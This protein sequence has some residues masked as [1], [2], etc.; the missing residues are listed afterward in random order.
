MKPTVK[1]IPKEKV[2]ILHVCEQRDNIEKLNLILVGNGH[3]E[4]G[5]VFKVVE[6]G[7]EI[8]NINEKLTGIS[9]IVKEL[10]EESVGKKEVIK[11]DKERFI[12]GI[13]TLG[14]LITIITLLFTAYNS[15]IG[16]KKQDIV[17]NKV[18]S[19]EYI[20][21]KEIRQMEGVSKVTRG[22]Y[23]PYNDHGLSD[24]IKITR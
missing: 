1:R 18:D 20:M 11:T 17:I 19:T 14:L 13:K 21:K 7:K 24:S 5:Y 23:V 3:P 2:A 16:N 12:S 22:G 10:H 9:G 15:F 6:M 4:E 8:K